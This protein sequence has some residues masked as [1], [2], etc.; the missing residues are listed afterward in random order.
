M[1]LHTDG[2]FTNLFRKKGQFI[3]HDPLTLCFTKMLEGDHTTYGLT[4]D[5]L[6]DILDDFGWIELTYVLLQY[7]PEIQR[8]DLVRYNPKTEADFTTWKNKVLSIHRNTFLMKDEVYDFFEDPMQFQFNY[9]CSDELL[10]TTDYSP[11]V[12]TLTYGQDDDLTYCKIILELR[13]E[14]FKFLPW[15]ENYKELTLS[16]EDVESNL[17][18]LNKSIELLQQ[19][20]YT[21]EER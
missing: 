12:I 9:K 20:G 19:K 16:K 17:K 8:E 7:S 15:G 6:Q 5:T 10:F 3:N 1:N 2:S 4:L 13:E 18:E 14:L 21:K 11:G